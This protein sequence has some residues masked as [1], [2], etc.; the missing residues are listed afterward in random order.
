MA[1]GTAG[2]SGAE[3][4]NLLNESALH[5]ARRNK[6]KVDNADIEEARDK[7]LYGRERRRVMDD[8]EKKM[9]AY[10]EAGHALLGALL[11][12]DWLPV[13]KVTILPRGRALGMAMYLPIKEMLSYHKKR[14]LNLIA[15][16][17]LK[18]W[19]LTIFQMGLQVTSSKS[20]RRLVPWSVTGA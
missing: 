19:P 20:P 13:H 18:N 12:G 5:A 17:L 2:L 9:T 15:V 3:L 8:D 14:L 11:N 4:A 10:H 6:K 1:R 16:G 7:I